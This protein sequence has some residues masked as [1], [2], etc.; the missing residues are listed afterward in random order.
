MKPEKILNRLSA[1]FVIVILLL[2]IIYYLH[3]IN[4]NLNLEEFNV[5]GQTAGDD[6]QCLFNGTCL[7]S[8]EISR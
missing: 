7:T 6:G 1:N 5:G 8:N 3:L 4:E 2:V